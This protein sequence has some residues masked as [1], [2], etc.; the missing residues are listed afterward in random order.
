M[1]LPDQVRLERSDDPSVIRRAFLR[2]SVVGWLS[3]VLLFYGLWAMVT[4]A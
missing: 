4:R 3:T 1:L 2:W